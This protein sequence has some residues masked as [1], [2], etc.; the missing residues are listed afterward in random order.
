MVKIGLIFFVIA[1]YLLV[2]SWLREIKESLKLEDAFDRQE[3][4]KQ[5]KG[6]DNGSGRD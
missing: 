2:R 1:L 4:R 6:Y 5:R 3:R